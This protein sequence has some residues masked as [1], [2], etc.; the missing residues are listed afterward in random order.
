M[1][2]FKMKWICYIMHDWEESVRRIGLGRYPEHRTCLRCKKE[3]VCSGFPWFT[4]FDLDADQYRAEN[5][6]N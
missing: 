2:G 6:S 1:E 3:Q 4:W 5:E